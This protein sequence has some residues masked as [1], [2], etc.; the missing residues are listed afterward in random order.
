MVLFLMFN[1]HG[2]ILILSPYLQFSLSSGRL[3]S[4]MYSFILRSLWTVGIDFMKSFVICL[5]IIMVVCCIYA[6]EDMKDDC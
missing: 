1:S 6:L 3:S 4:V 5:T 2:S